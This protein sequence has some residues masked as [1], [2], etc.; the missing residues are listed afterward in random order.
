V[1]RAESVEAIPI[2]EW[3]DDRLLSPDRI[4]IGFW[5][6]Q[7]KALMLDKLDEA[8]VMTGLV[9]FTGAKKP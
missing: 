5:Q 9:V 7:V 6:R 2:R 4:R 1:R 8:A 3:F